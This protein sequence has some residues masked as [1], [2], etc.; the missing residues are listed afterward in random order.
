[1]TTV[2]VMDGMK[3]SLSVCIIKYRALKDISDRCLM[4]V[5]TDNSSC[6]SAVF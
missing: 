3:T 6:F 5:I 1:M 4:P 2:Y